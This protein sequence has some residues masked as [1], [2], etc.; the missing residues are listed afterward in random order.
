MT[1]ILVEYFGVTKTSRSQCQIINESEDFRGNRMCAI[2][3]RYHIAWNFPMADVSY[4]FPSVNLHALIFCVPQIISYEEP[5]V[6][7]KGMVY[8]LT[9]LITRLFVN[10]KDEWGAIWCVQSV[11]IVAG[12][13]FTEMIFRKST[14]VDN[15]LV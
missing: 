1:R 11:V 14:K 4:L 7:M 12:V 5:V 3:G 15:K 8:L 9:G 10:N 6:V 13:F 2:S